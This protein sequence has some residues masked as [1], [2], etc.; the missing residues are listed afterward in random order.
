[1]AGFVAAFLG[2]ILAGLLTAE[3]AAWL[4]HIARWIVARAVGR[5]PPSQR[6]R[7]LEEWRADLAQFEHRPLAGLLHAI[8]I[9]LGARAVARELT[10]ARVR[11]RSATHDDKANAAA[12][13]AVEESSRRDWFLLTEIAIGMSVVVATAVYML[14]TWLGA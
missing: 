1:M 3:F 14:L 2:R 8:G 5:L 7:W 6:N 4:P 10:P 11:T 12:P 9:A 13:F